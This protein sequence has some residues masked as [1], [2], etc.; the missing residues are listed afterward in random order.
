[1]NSRTYDNRGQDSNSALLPGGFAAVYARFL[2]CFFFIFFRTYDP[3]DV[4]V[5][6]R[7]VESHQAEMRDHEK[8]AMRTGLTQQDLI[9][10]PMGPLKYSY[11][12]PTGQ[13]L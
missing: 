2:M 13:C 12:L 7:H 10:Y 11:T 6:L 9:S 5:M 8:P 4:R 1:M 3:I